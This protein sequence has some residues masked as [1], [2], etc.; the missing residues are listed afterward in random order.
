MIRYIGI[1]DRSPGTRERMQRR[2]SHAR[3]AQQLR[4][5]VLPVNGLSHDAFGIMSLDDGRADVGRLQPFELPGDGVPLAAIRVPAGIVDDAQAPPV[6]GEPQVG[7]VLA[8]LEPVFGARSKH[9]V[10][11]GNAARDQVVDQHAD[12]RLVPAR[13]PACFAGHVARR[14]DAGE[15]A[16][17]SRL[18]VAGRAVDLPGEEK[19]GDRLRFK[20]R[21]QRAWIE[22]VVL[23]RI[24]GPEDVGMLAPGYRVHEG[25]L[26]VEGQRRR[27]AVRINFRRFKPFRLEENLV[28]VALGEADD[29]VLDRRTVARAD[30]LDDARVERRAVEPAADDVVGLRRWY[31]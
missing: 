22:I 30:A 12:I 29:L 18:L 1:V 14:V 15:D 7:V 9:P 23:D 20:R 5:R 10:R 21:A 28:A 27:N 31:A 8:Q 25:Q 2:I 24:A 4:Q 3:P 11:L 26:Y 6:L 17:R 19:A 16:L 13:A